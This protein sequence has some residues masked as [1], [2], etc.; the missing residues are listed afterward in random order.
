MI[1]QDFPFFHK[2]SLG[3]NAK[4]NLVANV[5]PSARYF[6]A[7]YKLNTLSNFRH[8]WDYLKIV[9][10]TLCHKVLAS[11]PGL[12]CMSER[13]DPGLPHFTLA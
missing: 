2:D 11:F 1:R 9:T 10:K 6:C 12:P 7:W 5:H 3:G 4:T 13:S 8:C